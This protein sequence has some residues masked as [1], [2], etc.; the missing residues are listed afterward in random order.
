VHTIPDCLFVSLTSATAF[1]P[2]DAMPYTK[3]AKLVMGVES[4]LSF[5][6]AAVLVA[7]AVSIARG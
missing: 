5:V 7:R 3:W 4:M 6:I 2:T 1:S